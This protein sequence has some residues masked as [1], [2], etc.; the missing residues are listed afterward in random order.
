MVTR[1]LDN[2]E[3]SVLWKTPERAMKL[4][5]GVPLPILRHLRLMNLIRTLKLVSD[6]SIF[7]SKKFEEFPFRMGDIK[8]PEDL[9]GIFTTP[10]DIQTLPSSHFLCGKPN[11]AFET[12][13]TVSKQSKRIF[14]STREIQDI[15]RIGA[16]G[17]WR[18]GI[19][20]ADRVAS[21]FDY[22]F[23]VS[24]PTLKQ[25]LLELDAFP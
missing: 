9:G 2:I 19:R 23:W 12:T 25:S 3:L 20:A 18:L 14:F 16:A 13:G 22:S 7:Y 11:I 6:K 17:L 15:G 8:S 24:G 5:E 1:I 21:S 4:Y 10:Q